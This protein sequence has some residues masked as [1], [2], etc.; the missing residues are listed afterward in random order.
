MTYSTI[1]PALDREALA[2]DLLP[3]A[4][5][6]AASK[7]RGKGPPELA[8]ACQDAATEAIVRA[9]N[10]ADDVA[11]PA[12]YAWRS[13]VVAVGRAIR[14][15]YEYW[16]ADDRPTT[17]SLFDPETGETIDPKGR[18]AAAEELS[19]E[20]RELLPR[21]LA[22]AVELCCLEGLTHP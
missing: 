9:L 21:E 14:D 15:W 2:R 6:F 12:A 11:N 20:L 4:H 8:E 3:R 7:A 1:G 16:H 10:R 22:D 17:V 18:P 13:V 5:K 19:G